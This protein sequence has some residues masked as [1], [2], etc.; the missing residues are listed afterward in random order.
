MNRQDI[1]LN[2]NI[3][4]EPKTGPNPLKLDVDPEKLV[5][6]ALSNR[7]DTVQWELELAIEELDL[8]LNRNATLPDLSLSYSYDAQ[9]SAGDI[10]HAFGDFRN[11]TSDTHIVSLSARIPMGNRAA[12]ARLEQARLR[13]LQSQTDYADYRQSIQQEVYDRVRDLNNSWRNILAAEQN[14]EAALRTYKVEQSQFQIG[15]RTSTEVSDS[16]AVLARAQLGRINA[17][18]DYEIAQIYLAR[19]TGA[20]LGYSRIILEPTDIQDLSDIRYATK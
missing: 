3:R 15:N 19:A 11:K 9:T 8:E 12:K 20:L 17:L 14:V 6:V 5:E 4:I 13:Q 18:V 1:P 10:E 7:M 2:A 16:S